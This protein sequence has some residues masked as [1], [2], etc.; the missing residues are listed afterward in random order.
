M[1]NSRIEPGSLLW[2]LTTTPT[3]PAYMK[4]FKRNGLSQEAHT[5]WWC[6]AEEDDQRDS[7]QQL[8]SARALHQRKS[9]IAG[10]SC[11]SWIYQR[12]PPRH[13]RRY[14][15]ADQYWE[16]LNW[17]YMLCK[18]NSARPQHGEGTM[19]CMGTKNMC[20]NA[21]CCVNGTP[22]PQLIHIPW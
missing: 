17:W 4:A 10:P 16:Q 15:D 6:T 18:R 12:K 11:T 13:R 7:S 20:I 3:T 5:G 19:M 21:R 9:S 22:Q 14:D 2:L 1:L 8:Q